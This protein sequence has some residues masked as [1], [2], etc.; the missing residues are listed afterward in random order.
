MAA[1][2]W[3]LDGYQNG[4]IAFALR[5][6]C[7]LKSQTLALPYL[8]ILPQDK[9]A[10]PQS[11][12]VQARVDYL[13]KHLAKEHPPEEAE[14]QRRLEKS[15]TEAEKDFTLVVHKIRDEQAKVM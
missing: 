11:K 9:T 2:L 15:G 14:H 3:S 4:S 6:G 1:R 7:I 13:L 10:R 5:Q 8:Q 12:H